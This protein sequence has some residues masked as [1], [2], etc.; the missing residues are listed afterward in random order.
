MAGKGT[1]TRKFGACKPA[2]KVAGKK[3]L[4]WCLYGIKDHISP[5]DKIIAVTTQDFQR[6]FNLREIVIE[7]LSL[8]KLGVRLDFVEVSKT[9]AGPAATVNCSIPY[10]DQNYPA[11]IVNV[12]QY[13]IFDFP[14]SRK[15]WDAFLPLYFNQHG[16]SSYVKIKNGLISEIGEKK[17]IS[18]YASSGIYAFYNINNLVNMLDVGL[19]QPPN[20]RNE[21]FISPMINSLIIEKKRVLPASVTFKCDLGSEASLNKFNTIISTFSNFDDDK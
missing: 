9:P 12:D 15:T 14:D 1:R 4:E 8:N 7:W 20:Y 3:I 11:I 2:I 17:L 10:L 5:T 13:C 6:N 16:K 21:Y 18:F 19:S